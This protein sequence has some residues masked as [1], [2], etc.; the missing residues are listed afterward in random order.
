M[1]KLL[2][3]ICVAAFISASGFTTANAQSPVNFGLRAGLNF[4]NFNDI[5]GDRPDSR[6]GLMVGGYLNFKVPMSPL[7]ST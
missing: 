4:A 3:L 5:N 7:Y 6:T 1:K 2:S